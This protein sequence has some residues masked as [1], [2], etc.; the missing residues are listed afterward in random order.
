[1]ILAIVGSTSLD[2]HPAAEQ[3]I[4]EVLD[5]YTPDVVVS[6]GAPGI[7]DMAA[8]AARRRGVTVWELK[9]SRKAW[10]PVGR[11][12]FK[13]RNVAVAQVC[14]ILVRIYDP[15][16]TTYGSGWTRDRAAELGKPTREI[17]IHV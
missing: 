9:P 12:G 16:T 3:A 7:D 1:V 11:T 4:E 15:A 2:G 5:Q 17:A 6:G 10:D 13:R 14:D 8:T